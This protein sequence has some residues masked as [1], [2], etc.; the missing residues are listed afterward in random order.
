MGPTRRGSLQQAV[1]ALQ[2]AASCVLFLHVNPD[3]DSVGSSLGLGLALERLGRRVAYAY[4]DFFP[5]A[6]RFL[7]GHER[8]RPW[9]EI[10]GD[11]DLAVALDCSSPE[12]VGDAEPLLRRCRGVLNVDHHP[13]NPG[14]GDYYWVEP[15]RSCVGEMVF[16]LVEAL[17]V[18]LE[19][20]IAYAIYTAIV[21]D[22]GSFRY[23]QTTSLT[24]R[25]AAALL[26]AG[27]RP[28]RVGL[29]LFENRS[30]AALRLLRAALASLEFSEDERLAWMTVTQA[31]MAETGAR[32]EDAEG[33]IGYA[34]S[35][36]PVELALLFY[37]EPDGRV[38]VSFRSKR[39]V[40]VSRLAAAF[41][42]GGHVRAAGC[43][44]PGPVEAVRERVLAAARAA[45]RE[46]G[47][48]APSGP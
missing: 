7:E 23:E 1:T 34:R 42:G 13:S 36:A 10:E 48:P 26:D 25:Y 32:P 45:L 14:F 21:T 6:F 46:A 41:G 28:E 30:P 5:S 39:A 29:A 40:D 3:G 11:F 18:P 16:E 12:R 44:L 47:V 31:V 9:H 22:T 24:L 17:G 2:G 19:P 33:L 15:D 43:T 37:E 27:V 4:A 20:A 38:R 8:F 35:V